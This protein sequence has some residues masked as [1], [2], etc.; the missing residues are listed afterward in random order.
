MFSDHFPEGI[1]DST[2]IDKSS[3]WTNLGDIDTVD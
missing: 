1:M 3:G 2:A